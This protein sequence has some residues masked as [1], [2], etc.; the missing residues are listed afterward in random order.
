[1]VCQGGGSAARPIDQI[2]PFKLVKA[3]GAAHAVRPVNDLPWSPWGHDQSFFDLPY[4]FHLIENRSDKIF[5]YIFIDLLDHG[6]N[7]CPC[8]PAE[9][10][11]VIKYELPGRDRISN[12][13]VWFCPLLSMPIELSPEVPIEL[14]PL[15]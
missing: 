8:L 15:R 3:I 9:E 11:Q 4:Q 14:S 2:R 12:T 1:L 13:A 10:W 7:L 5:G 6:H